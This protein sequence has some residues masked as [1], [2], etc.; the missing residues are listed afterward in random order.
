[1]GFRRKKV[2]VSYMPERQPI[3]S[4][5]VWG[6][7]A[8][9]FGVALVLLAARAAMGGETLLPPD[10]V[11]AYAARRWTLD[12]GLP[13][14][15]VCGVASGRDGYV[16]LATARY[17]VRFDGRCFVPIAAPVSTGRNEGLF[18]D[19]G[20][21]LWLYGSFGA[22]RYCDGRWWQPGASACGALSGRVNSVT[23]GKGRVLYFAQDAAVYA[24]QDGSVRLVL[25]RSAFP[26]E[27][28]NFRQ[29]TWGD[30][31]GLWLVV[32]KGLYRWFPGGNA[33]PVRMTGLRADWVLSSASGHPVVA[34][35]AGVCLR[36]RSSNWERLTDVRAVSARCVQEMP[37]GTLW[38]G[39]DAGVDV[40]SGN[41]WHTQTHVALHGPLQVLGITAD[42][43]NNI[44]LATAD[45]L[46]RLRRRV[47]RNVLARAESGTSDVSALWSDSGGR[48]WAV[49][50]SGVLTAGDAEGLDPL[51]V[52]PGFSEVS[53]NALY[54]ESNGTL[55]S[56]CSGGFLWSLQNQ[57]LLRIEGAYAED[58]RAM[59]GRGGPPLWVATH[60]GVL[61]LDAERNV[62]TETDWPHDPVHSLWLDPNGTL[63]VGHESLGLAVRKPGGKIAF[64]KESDVPGRT[65]RA[66]YR[67]R[68]GL[69]W[70]GGLEG[71]ARWDGERRFVFRRTHGL[72]NESIRQIS[73]D[74]VGYLWLGT[75]DGVERIAKQDLAD[76][77]T[78]KKSVLPVRTFGAESGME[79]TACVGGVFF[80]NGEPPGDRLWFPTRGG[81]VTVETR[82]LPPLRPAP[83]VRL[84]ALELGRRVELRSPDGGVPV[85]RRGNRV[86]PR[87]VGITFTALD[88]STPERVRFRYELSGPVEQQS[89]LT[90]D[91]RAVFSRLPPGGYVF[92]VTACNG[93]GVWQPSGVTVAWTVRPFFW[94]TFWFRIGCLLLVIAGVGAGARAWERRRI[95]HR[96]D[97]AK[98]EQG[99][100][101]ERARIARDLHDEIGAKL[102]RLTLLG[103]MAAEDA[104]GDEPLLR[105][106]SEMADTAR[107]THRAFDEIV[108]SVSP[109][110]DTVRSLSHYI[111]KYAEEFFMGTEV[112]CHCRLP[113][114]LTD[115]PLDPQNRHQM[116]LA[117]KESL[118]NVLKHAG[119]KR[120]DLEIK[121]TDGHLRVEVNDDGCGFDPI[122]V[123]LQGEGLRN[124]QERMKA[125]RGN[126]VIEGKVGK[127]CR[128]IFDM[129]V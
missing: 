41:A 84:T 10:M 114:D 81:L 35:G 14:S 127:G 71:L 93:D 85:D 112:L 123:G 30:D 43:E 98:R 88:F 109:R 69:L 75:A 36:R 20:G 96:L 6:N 65:V 126:L 92:R 118:H 24:W 66:L 58:V 50:R 48:V 115:C 83:V 111:C 91:R 110:N 5:F 56:G 70:V 90:E 2:V 42:L 52:P 80:P 117:V 4:R 49:Q 60:R 128:V 53:P 105:E 106:V 95:R 34:Y 3:P 63:W 57:S 104:K 8:A 39:H 16:W 12:D 94:E 31:G 27:T 64:S 100:A 103:A 9:L 26:N 67:D 99:L 107:E 68:E 76:V 82:A 86:D 44:W 7:R 11:G 55:W 77:A 73:E 116:F 54:R 89:G 22:V 38:V 72:W 119:A 108:W 40:F 46:V 59:V 32:G 13:D 62:L 74:G 120:V 61:A 51:L 122:A 87:D 37:G 121:Q 25:A 29:L 113:D 15:L 125:V 21:G 102:T 1:M 33:Q 18:L 47:M 101:R 19:S 129:P 97:A 17:L 28:G 79:N 23:E 124:M 45:G 78:G